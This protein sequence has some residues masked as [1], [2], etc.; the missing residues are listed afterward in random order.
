M[1]SYKSFNNILKKW[2][3]TVTKSDK[4]T[5]N[6]QGDASLAGAKYGVYKGEQLIDT[7]TTDKNGQ[8]SK[9]LARKY[10][11]IVYSIASLY[12]KLLFEFL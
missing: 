2:H 4:E 6:P 12:P 3:L 7:Y 8:F 9:V 11:F 10:P 1:G 5:G